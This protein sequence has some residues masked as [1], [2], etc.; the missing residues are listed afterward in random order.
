M[1]FTPIA[2][3]KPYY[4]KT[5]FFEKKNVYLLHV[6][7]TWKFSGWH[8]SQFVLEL[9][10]PEMTC[11]FLIQL[12]LYVRSPVS[13]AISLVMVPPTPPLLKKILDQ[14]LELILS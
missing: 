6:F 9:R 14:P 3:S 11:G 1:Y 10:D 4:Q 5:N 2:R 12:V 13:Y 8:L 7:L